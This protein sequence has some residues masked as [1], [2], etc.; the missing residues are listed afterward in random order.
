[1]PNEKKKQSHRYGFRVPESLV[2]KFQERCK[3]TGTTAPDALRAYMRTEAEAE[4]Q[5]QALKARAAAIRSQ[6]S[7]SSEA[8][9]TDIGDE[10]DA[11]FAGEKSEASQ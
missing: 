11:L 5:A 4:E 9:K 6:Q 2:K 8:P 1:M 7:A 10:L 3:N